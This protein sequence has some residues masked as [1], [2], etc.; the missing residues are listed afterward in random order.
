MGPPYVE[1]RRLS[2]VGSLLPPSGS[3][4]KLRMSCLAVDDFN[5]G[6]VLAGLPED[7]SVLVLKHDSGAGMCLSGRTLTSLYKALG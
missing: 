3:G 1:V 4:D 5:H 7:F 2:G 6:T